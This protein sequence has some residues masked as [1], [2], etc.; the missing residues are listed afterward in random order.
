M[1]GTEFRSATYPV[2]NFVELKAIDSQQVFRG[3]LESRLPNSTWPSIA[4]ELTH[5]WCF[6]SPVGEAL[7]H[8]YFRPILEWNGSSGGASPHQIEKL[9]YRTGNDFITYEVAY[10]ALWPIIE[11]MAL[12]CE[13][14]LAPDPSSVSLSFPLF[15]TYRLYAHSH[16]EAQPSP[17]ASH[18]EMDTATASFL[19][20]VR[21]SR[22]MIRRKA[23]ILAQPLTQAEEGYLAGY[24]FFKNLWV[25]LATRDDRFWP[26]D[27]FFRFM[28]QFI[29][30]DMN[31]VQKLLRPDDGVR[32]RFTDVSGYIVDRLNYIIG[33]GLSEVAD[34][35]LRHIDDPIPLGSTSASITD[36][37][38]QKSI[39]LANPVTSRDTA[40]WVE[41][42]D[43]L[44]GE[45]A[46]L[47]QHGGEGDESVHDT[48]ATLIAQRQVFTIVEHEVE[49]V[50]DQDGVASVYDGDHRAAMFSSSLGPG[51]LNG[52]MGAYLVTH[53][54]AS[55]V[56]IGANGGILTFQFTHNVTHPFAEQVSTFRT[57]GRNLLDSLASLRGDLEDSVAKDSTVQVIL[58]HQRNWVRDFRARIARQH[59]LPYLAGV[60]RERVL[61]QFD[62]SNS[63]ASVVESSAKLRGLAAISLI[64]SIPQ[65]TT[66]FAAELFRASVDA[67]GC[68]REYRELLVELQ[69]LGFATLRDKLVYDRG[70]LVGFSAI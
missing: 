52:T 63:F 31:L 34:P 18:L 3:L 26:A 24:L 51:T 23:S 19:L 2:T 60:E 12:F 65:V 32:D 44:V 40:A 27:N 8:L 46:T 47:A 6:L 38:H 17:Q 21:T 33:E 35:L 62:S 7:T 13:F 70:H 49:I 1:T 10:G 68:R 36:Y 66:E 41:G 43:L 25:S 55:F 28:H 15:W 39:L 29:F 61:V 30:C 58:E 59:A 45:K 4:H 64:S 50:V 11:G 20:D 42:I 54:G 57:D 67:H 53:L 9:Q 48:L 69:Q 56:A 14:D 5:H 22:G 37:D 16:Q